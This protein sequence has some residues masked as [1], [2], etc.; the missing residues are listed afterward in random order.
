MQNLSLP[1]AEGK[2]EPASNSTLV[3]ALEYASKGWRVLPLHT[4]EGGGCSCGGPCRNAGKHTRNPT[5]CSGAT[6]DPEQLRR[7]WTEL[8]AANVGIATGSASGI[9]VIDVDGEAGQA[10]LRALLGLRTLPPTRK[11][12]TGRC[13]TSGKRTGFHLYF[14]SPNGC[15]LRNSA[16]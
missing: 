7:W 10:S 12:L 13:D 8:P 3:A 16:G 9:C 11:V 2:R 14:R 1:P 6:A 5:G 4:P 15:D